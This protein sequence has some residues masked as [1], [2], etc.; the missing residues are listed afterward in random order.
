MKQSLTDIW[1][2]N[3]QL[4]LKLGVMAHNQNPRTQKAE[5]EESYESKAGLN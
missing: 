4:S 3:I 1:L 2:S 5:A